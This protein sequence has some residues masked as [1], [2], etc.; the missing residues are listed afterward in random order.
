MGMAGLF[1]NLG[2]QIGQ[3]GMSNLGFQGDLSQGM[4]GNSL[5]MSNLNNSRAQQRLQNAT[6]LFGFGNE[7]AQQDYNMGQGFFGNMTGMDEQMRQWIALGGNIG[8]TQAQAGAN[9]GQFMMQNSGSPGGSFLSSLGTGLMGQAIDRMP[10][11]GT[12]GSLQPMTVGGRTP[13][14]FSGPIP[15]MAQMPS[16]TGN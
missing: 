7:L 9:Q 15:A 1:G 5:N 3:S 14:G 12:S 8:G 10:F 11:G 16:W 6:G 13:V 2:S 4:F